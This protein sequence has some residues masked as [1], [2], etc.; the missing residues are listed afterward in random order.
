MKRTKIKD[1]ALPRYSKGEERFNMISHIVGGGFSI[2]AL[3]L[4]ILKAARYG[5]AEVIAY[6]T[7]VR[8]I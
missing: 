6:G 5:A 4:C 7:A 2:L 3:I 1:R 8:F